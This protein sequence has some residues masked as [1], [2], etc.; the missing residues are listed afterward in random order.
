MSTQRT[1]IVRYDFDSSLFDEFNNE[2]YAKDFW[3]VVY[4]LSDDKVKEA[5][6]GET[7]DVYQRMSS[8]LAHDKKKKLTAVHLIDS[9]IFNKSATLDIESNLIKYFSGDGQ[10]KL[11]NG[12]VGLANHNYYQKNEVYWDVF[13][14]IWNNL[15]AEGIAKHSLEHIDNSD[16]FKYS[17]YKSLS[18][19][20][21][22][23]LR[24][25]MQDLLDEKFNTIIVEGGAGTGKTI[26]AI[27]LFK[28]LNTDLSDFNYSEFGIE[29]SELVVLIRKLKEQYPN[30]RMALVV[31]MASF[32]KTLKKVFKNIKG[33]TTKMVIGP[34]EVAKEKFDIVIVDES[35]RLRR[36]VN[37][38]AY[39]G[40]FDKACEK[41]GLDKSKCSELD[42][43]NIQS[44]K[45]V[46]FY[47]ENQSIK[48]SD[49]LK[50]SFDILKQSNS[51]RVEK[52]KSQFR[53]RGGNR[54][55]S[56]VSDLLSCS[57]EI[58]PTKFSSNDYELVLFDSL[59]DMVSEVKARDHEVGLS[60]L[61]A[62]YS[63]PWVSNKDKSKFDIEIEGVRLQWNSIAVDWVN[64]ENA[65]NEVGCI[66]TTQGYDLNYT[67]VIFGNE[68]GY[69]PESDQIIISEKEYYDKNGKQSIKDPAELK[70]FIINIYKTIL[71]RGIRGTYIYVCDDNLREYFR[72]VIAS[73]KRETKVIP[74]YDYDQVNP[75]VD[76]VPL[77]D[78]QAAA[79]DFSDLQKVEESSWIKVPSHVQASEQLFACRVI[80]ESMNKVIPNGS[81][82]LF[83]KA[84]GGSRSG[85]IVLVESADLHDTDF[86][87]GYTVKEYTS[88]KVE[89]EDGWKHAKI[90]LKPLST[91]DN[92][93]PI[94]LTEDELKN[95]KVIGEFERVL[96]E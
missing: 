43:V 76:S 32:R 69:D 78:L 27:F 40:A 62:G 84:G 5:Y 41:L 17:P 12:N 55:V 21:V 60:R 89:N 2:H 57:E 16:L 38:G 77:Y 67:G 94:E 63:W 95:F 83:K 30:P 93:K 86:G 88:V 23:G 20:Q 14:E 29:E 13:K 42:W 80:G 8:H 68:I 75:F 18:R 11:M 85:K 7:T 51:T 50:E 82:C 81:I 48:P 56:F 6:V 28:L 22:T 90:V 34:A 92:Y 45:A 91:D 15:R 1:K 25:I 61:V 31:P 3:P 24:I 71:L 33:L 79:G 87:A 73:Y 65:I 19:D 54:Y 26:L 47:D 49:A 36:R 53:V 96:H 44:K 59:R 52:L 39:Y 10:Y 37:L 74:L 64:S 35:H 72:K 70:D 58:R 4:I 46:L 9:N 66:H